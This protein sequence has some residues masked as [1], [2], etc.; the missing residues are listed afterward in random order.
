MF[1]RWLGGYLALQREA[2][3]AVGNAPGVLCGLARLD[4]PRGEK[5][6]GFHRAGVRGAGRM[7]I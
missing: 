3:G 5:L 2:Q 6:I 1:L 4:T 7:C